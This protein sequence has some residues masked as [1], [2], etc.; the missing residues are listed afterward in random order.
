MDVYSSDEDIDL[1]IAYEA[2]PAQRSARQHAQ[3][4]FSEDISDKVFRERYR[5]P[6]AV[7]DHLEE[8]L[9]DKLQ[10]KSGRNNPLSPR[11]QIKI[12]LH[13]LGTNSFYHVLRDCHGVSTDTVF[14]TVH[15]VCD[16]LFELRNDYIQW[17]E[18]TDKLAR[19]FYDIA[20]M[21]SVC[22]CIDG[23]H[24]P[25]LPPKEDEAACVNR[26]HFHS[27][28]VMAVCG[29]DLKIFYANSRAGGRWHDSR[30]RI[31]PKITRHS[32]YV[33]T[34]ICSS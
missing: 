6:R 32:F 22:G 24:V 3:R 31:C 12:F 34:Q 16:E 11:D 2:M 13:F 14:R 28:N 7:V 18:N 29:P 4:Q 23:T 9:G 26:H 5:V 15:R 8:K 21:P 27:L 17:P 30:V 25:V 1:A 19:E 10:H 20:K 33:L